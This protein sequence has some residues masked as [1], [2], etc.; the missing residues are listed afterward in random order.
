MAP[1]RRLASMLQQP[2]LLC[3][4]M[5]QQEMLLEG[6]TQHKPG[7]L[8]TGLTGSSLCRSR[9]LYPQLA[10]LAA[11]WI[12]ICSGLLLFQCATRALQD[13]ALA[14][15]LMLDLFKTVLHLGCLTVYARLRVCF[16]AENGSKSALR[17]QQEPKCCRWALVLP[18]ILAS[19]GM[20][21]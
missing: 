20:C 10:L 11:P 14:F 7:G 4:R 8:R 18:T 19:D 9:I 16:A 5:T 6:C 2:Q 1:G 15:T 13:S 17:Q 3:K 12:P 21:P